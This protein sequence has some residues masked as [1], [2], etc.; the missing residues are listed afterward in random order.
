MTPI[1]TDRAISQLLWDLNR[2][3]TGCRPFFPSR[4]HSFNTGDK[5]TADSTSSAAN[6]QFV[7]E[8]ELVPSPKGLRADITPKSPAQRPQLLRCYFVA[9][10]S[11]LILKLPPSAQPRDNVHGAPVRNTGGSRQDTHR[12]GE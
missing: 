1:V 8:E 7:P 10:A 5:V 9:S 6:E 11:R 4:R 2:Q 12:G 3:P